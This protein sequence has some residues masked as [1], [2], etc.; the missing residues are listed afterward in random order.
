[1]DKPEVK[2]I[3][4]TAAAYAFAVG[5][6]CGYLTKS[7]EAAE[8]RSRYDERKATVLAERRE[9]SRVTER[10]YETCLK[11]S[12]DTEKCLVV[13]YKTGRKRLAEWR[14]AGHNPHAFSSY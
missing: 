11:S 2:Q 7:A 10:A 14:N 13:G 8:P 4:F 6:L 5:F 12:R 9:V 3:A 1:M